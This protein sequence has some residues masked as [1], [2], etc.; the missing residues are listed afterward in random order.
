MDAANRE[1]FDTFVR[2]S[3]GRYGIEVDDVDLAV[4]RVA[5]QTYGPGRDALMAADLS[6]VPPEHDLDPSRAPSA[7]R[8]M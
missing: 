6:G 4:M 5:E 3:L 7:P 2:L 8:A 1:Q